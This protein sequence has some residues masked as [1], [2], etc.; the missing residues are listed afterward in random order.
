MVNRDIGQ[1]RIGEAL[2]CDGWLV[3]V[4]CLI[5]KGYRVVWIR[6]ITANIAHDGE[7][8]IAGVFFEEIF[9]DEL[10]N[11]LIKVDAVDEDL[12]GLLGAIEYAWLGGPTSA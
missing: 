2:D 3:E 12:S 4:G 5:A 6:R 8:A 1:R 9:G 11:G 10:G 7:F